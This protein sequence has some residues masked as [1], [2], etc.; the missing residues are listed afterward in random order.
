LA[1]RGRRQPT[2]AL[3]AL[4]EH[5]AAL[6]LERPA[7]YTELAER[8]RESKD[9][10]V[11]L[12]LALHSQGKRVVGYGAT[13]KSTTVTNFCG[14]DASLVEFVSDTT[15]GKQGKF[16][17]GAHIPVVPYQRFRDAYPDY[18]L[19]FA[20]NHGAE[21]IAKEEGFRQHGG[22]FIL[23]VPTVHIAE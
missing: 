13:S 1:R 7:T 3:R 16:S 8:I 17:P 23:Y 22:K 10:L 11:A 4:Q 9:K 18:A 12:L 14:I 21:I 20:W 6:G 5:E 19:L 15:P 2:V